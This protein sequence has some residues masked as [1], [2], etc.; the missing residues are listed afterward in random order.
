MVDSDGCNRQSKDE[1]DEVQ[2]V[3]R[4]C[5]ESGVDLHNGGVVCRTHVGH[6]IGNALRM[7]VA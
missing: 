6:A 7:E 2:W 1:A 4:H 5:C 3:D